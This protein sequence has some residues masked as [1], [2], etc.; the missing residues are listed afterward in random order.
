M[1]PPSLNSYL[2]PLLKSSRCLIPS[3]QGEAAHAEAASARPPGAK[4]YVLAQ[5]YVTN[6]LLI[7]GRK[8]G[9]R[10]WL[11][12]TGT[13]PLRAYLHTG[14]LVLFSTA[15]YDAAAVAGDSLA[16]GR[17]ALA[18]GGARA[19][20]GAGA[21][22]GGAALGHVTNYAQN[23]DGTVWDVAAL[24]EH[25][26]EEAWQGLW[27]RVSRNAAMVAAA[28]LGEVSAEAAKLRLPANSSFEVR[29]NS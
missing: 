21:G 12:I 28:A 5:R 9:L 27:R 8:W 29:P 17:D 26:G 3:Q 20:A 10:V 16:G 25:L 7:G 14:G 15:A 2:N 11:L 19:G 6:P 23:V 4:P 22:G 18:Q 1:Q 24:A 13:D